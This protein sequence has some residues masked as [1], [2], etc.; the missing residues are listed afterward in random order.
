LYKKEIPY[1]VEVVVESYK[2]GSE[3]VDIRASVFVVR[4]SQRMIIIGNKGRA[5]KLLGTE[6]RKDIEKFIGQH[7]YLDL[8]V[9]VRKDW[10]NNPDDLRRFGYEV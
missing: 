9:K 10:R 7:I 1:S 8:T 4:E 2:E 3:R 5:I 6:A